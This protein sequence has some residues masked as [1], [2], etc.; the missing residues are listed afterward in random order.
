MNISIFAGNIIFL[1][2][3]T[4]SSDST[5]TLFQGSSG[6]TSVFKLIGLIILCILII[7]ASYFTTKFVGKK[8]LGRYSKSNFKSLDTYRINGNKFLQIVQVGKR[9]FCISVTKDQISVISELNKE[10]IIN[11]PPEA[12]NTSFKDVLAGLR[13]KKQQESRAESQSPVF[14]VYVN[15][16]ADEIEHE[17]EDLIDSSDEKTDDI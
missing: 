16:E 8:Q 4:A 1:L 13:G 6:I 10:D 11:W 5:K 12:S 17:S 3:G 9:Y 15:S 14:P 2:S 7:A